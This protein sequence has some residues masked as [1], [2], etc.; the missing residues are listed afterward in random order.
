MLLMPYDRP[1]MYRMIARR[2]HTPCYLGELQLASVLGLQTATPRWR[3]A[4]CTLEWL[5]SSSR[6]V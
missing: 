1:C 6:T 5:T 2:D 3:S 4:Y